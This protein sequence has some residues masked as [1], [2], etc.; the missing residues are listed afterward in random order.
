MRRDQHPAAF[1]VP[2]ILFFEISEICALPVTS[3]FHCDNNFHDIIVDSPP[4]EAG[5]SHS[6]TEGG[7]LQKDRRILTLPSLTYSRGN[8][9]IV[10]ALDLSGW[11]FATAFKA[12]L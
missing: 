6:V 10:I 12:L 9:P 1:F 2:G 11:Q 8:H 4:D 5:N 7:C 3:H